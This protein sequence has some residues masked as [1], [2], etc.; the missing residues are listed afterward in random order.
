MCLDRRKF[1]AKIHT[2]QAN[3]HALLAV[4]LRRLLRRYGENTTGTLTPNYI[5]WTGLLILTLITSH[6]SSLLPTKLPSLTIVYTMF[7][8]V[9]P[10]GEH[11]F[12]IRPPA[13][14][15]PNRSLLNVPR[16]PVCF[17]PCIRGYWRRRLSRLRR[18]WRLCPR[19]RRKVQV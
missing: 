12:R 18:C 16:E 19:R 4:V 9:A 14:T 10:A 15:D 6:H 17:R 13:T 1:Q 7:Q 3:A 5:S 8:E 11:P 2:L